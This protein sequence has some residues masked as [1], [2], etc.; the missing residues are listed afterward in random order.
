MVGPQ[1]N[2]P[3]ARSLPSCASWV[4]GQFS[5]VRAQSFLKSRPLFLNA[6]RSGWPRCGHLFAEVLAHFAG[7]HPPR[8]FA[9]PVAVPAASDRTSR[10]G[11][12]DVYRLRSVGIASVPARR[13]RGRPIGKWESWTP[14]GLGSKQVRLTNKDRVLPSHF[15]M[16]RALG[17]LPNPVCWPCIDVPSYAMPDR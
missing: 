2:D 6:D 3:R 17:S 16:R 4:I 8:V 12:C 9:R 14:G 15:S 10:V 5:W 13:S 1:K 11:R 7:Y